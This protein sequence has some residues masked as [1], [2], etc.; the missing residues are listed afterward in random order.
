MFIKAHKDEEECIVEGKHERLIS[1]SLFIQVQQIL[2]GKAKNEQPKGKILV[3]EHLPLRGF[4]KC[5]RCDEHIS[6]SRSRGKL[7]VYY[8]Y[9]C[10]S[11]CGY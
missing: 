2:N 3:S 7:N 9:H 10:N 11:K 5:P 1:E 6:E 8:Y 4:L